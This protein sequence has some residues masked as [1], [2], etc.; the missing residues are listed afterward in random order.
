MKTITLSGI[1]PRRAIPFIHD[2]FGVDLG[3]VSWIP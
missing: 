1:V 3:A 2:Y